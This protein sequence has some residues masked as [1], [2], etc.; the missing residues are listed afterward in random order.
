M[1]IKTAVLSGILLA[2][3]AMVACGGG[4]T[5]DACAAPAAVPGAAARI[6]IVPLTSTEPIASV[7]VTLASAAVPGWN[8]I[9]AIGGASAL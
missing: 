1:E 7:R 5:A 3:S 6:S 4:F 8:E 2:S 9:D